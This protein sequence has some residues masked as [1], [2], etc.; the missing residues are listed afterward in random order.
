MHAGPATLGTGDARSSL[1]RGS[2]FTWKASEIN[3]KSLWNLDGF[4]SPVIL[5]GNDWNDNTGSTAPEKSPR[6]FVPSMKAA[7]SSETLTVTVVTNGTSSSAKPASSVTSGIV[8]TK[9]EGVVRITAVPPGNTGVKKN[10]AEPATVGVASAYVGNFAESSEVGLYP[11]ESPRN[12]TTRSVFRK[13]DVP[14]YTTQCA[15][16]TEYGDRITQATDEEPIIPQTT[17]N[18]LTLRT[19]SPATAY[20]ENNTGR[21]AGSITITSENIGT[22]ELKSSTVEFLTTSKVVSETMKIS[23]I[24]SSEATSTPRVTTVA[25]LTSTAPV[26]STAT[27]TATLVTTTQPKSTV[28]AFFTVSTVEATGSASTTAATPSS[29]SKTS[30]V[31]PTVTSATAVAVGQSSQ[32]TSTGTASV[33]TFITATTNTVPRSARTT[34]RSAAPST[35]LMTDYPCRSD[36]SPQPTGI[37]LQST[38]SEP[39]SFRIRFLWSF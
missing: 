37:T 33:P 4:L 11:T 8:G 31:V 39:T 23:E 18:L 1:K 13:T 10:T 20:P 32:S 9:S 6:S 15:H 17:E 30:T 35:A 21:D 36:P 26:T 34:E 19:L 3:D 16:T 22:T 29:P 2:N 24:S 28:T 7:D 25:A 12:T 27:T 5:M 38:T 14:C